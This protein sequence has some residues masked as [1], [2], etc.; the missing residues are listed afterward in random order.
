M[1]KFGQYLVENEIIDEETMIQVLSIQRRRDLIPIGEIALQKHMLNA[2]ELFDILNTQDETGAKFGETALNLGFLN[3]EQIK[4]LLKLQKTIHGTVGSI[5]V[6]LKKVDQATIDSALK[7]YHNECV[8]E[9]IG[10]STTKVPNKKNSNDLTNTPLSLTSE[11]LL[12]SKQ[13]CPICEHES[14]QE[15]INPELYS[16]VEYD[17]D[18][19]PVTYKW[20]SEAEQLDYPLIYNVWKCPKCSFCSLY[21]YFKDPTNDMTMSPYNFSKKIKNHINK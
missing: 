21:K 15:I 13:K 11:M 10:L 2:K 19:K 8:Q 1:K 5:L 4:I 6:E 14:I 12:K 9:K 3:K 18:F 16:I 20:K 7:L 17:I